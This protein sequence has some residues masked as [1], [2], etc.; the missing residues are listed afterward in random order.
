MAAASM[1]RWGLS[2]GLILPVTGL[3]WAAKLPPELAVITGL[4]PLKGALASF[5]HPII[6]LFM[7]G[8]ALAAALSHH[9]L[10]QA[11]ARGVLRVARGQRLRAVWLLCAVAA[12]LSMWMSN[13]A[14]AAL[15]LPLLLPVG[16]AL[17][18]DTVAMAMA[19][20]V[21]ASCA[22]ML[23]VATPP[24]AIVF[25]TDPVPQSAM[26]RCGFW[27]NIACLFV[28]AIHTLLWA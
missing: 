7:G 16:Q 20:A 23:P 14:S 21:A 27:L 15:L 17:G 9:G 24:N 4:L 3:L 1:A 12:L 18:L 13:T 10:D 6:F 22:F 5:A 8:F 28:I 2:L 25:A 11:M 26:M 19:I